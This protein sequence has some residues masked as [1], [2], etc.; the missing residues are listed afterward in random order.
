MAR[1]KKVGD[2]YRFDFDEKYH[3]YCQILEA[4]DVAFFDYYSDKDDDDIESILQKKE[5]FRIYCDQ[6]CFKGA[7]WKYLKTIELSENK[8]CI[9]YKY[10]I[11]DGKYSLYRQGSFTECSRE[12]CIGLEI[13]ALWTEKGISDRLNYSFFN[14][15]LPAHIKSDLPFYE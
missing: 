9:N 5:V 6:D 8:K 12:D 14:K 1:R 15:E 4:S 7:K 2:I 10:H 3:C 13:F 11:S